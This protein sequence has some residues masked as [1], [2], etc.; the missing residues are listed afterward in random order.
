[1]NKYLLRGTRPNPKNKF[2]K[3]KRKRKIN[4]NNNPIEVNIN[5]NFPNTIE[6]KNKGH[7]NKTFVK[8]SPTN[9]TAS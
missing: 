1:M 9:Q 3:K 6:E 7:A 4:T 5:Q 8:G 2:K